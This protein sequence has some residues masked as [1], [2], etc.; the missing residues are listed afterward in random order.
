VGHPPHSDNSTVS[1]SYTGRATSVQDEG[2]G[3]QR[4]QRISQ[5]NGLGRLAYVCE[6]TN[7]NVLGTGGTAANCGSQVSTGL[8]IAGTGFLTTYTYDALNNLKSVSQGGYLPRTFAY[9]SLSRLLTAANPES[10]TITYGYDNASRLTTR[11][12][13]K[14]SQ[15]NSSVTVTTTMGYDEINRLRTKTYADSDNSTTYLAPSVTLNYDQTSALG[16]SGLNYT[17]GRESSAV[18]AGSQ[19]GE[20]FSYDKLGRA[21]VNSQCTPQNCSANTVFPITYNY[22]LLGD[23]TSGTNGMGVALNYTVNR[24]LRL[25]GTTSSLSDSNHPGTLYSS[26]R[27]NAAGSVVSTT[28]GNTGSSISETRSYDGR[29]RLTNITDG[30][31]YT[32]TIPTN[33]YAPNS[34]IL[35]ANDSVNGNW[36]YGYDAFNRLVSANATAQP[37]T[38]AY[39]RFGNRW[40]QNGPH[41][42]SL[43]FGGNNNRMD[44]YSYD[45]AGNLLYDG[46]TN[47]TYDSESRLISAT[48]G[49]STYQYDADGRRIRKTTTA[50]GT[51]DFLYDL[52]GHEMTQ[53][54]SAGVWNRGEVYAGGRHLAT[55]SGGA[56]GMT[57]FNFSNWLGT[58]HARSIPGATTPCETIASLPFGDGETT[59]GSCGDPSPM[60]FTG[61]ERDSESGLDDF[62]ARYYS[63][64]YGRFM[65]PDWAANATAVPYADFGNPQ[66]LNLYGYVK[67]NPLSYADP[68][69]HCC[70]WQDLRERVGASTSFFGQELVGVGKGVINLVPSLYNTVATVLNAESAGT[71]MQQDLPLAPTV[72]LNNLGQVVGS[73]VITL[74]IAATGLTGEAP[75]EAAVPDSNAVV[76]GGASEMPAQGTTF[77]GAH[78]AT[79]EG[80]AQGVPHGQIRTSTA[81]E[82]R[83]AGGSVRSAP[84]PTRSG[85]MNYKHVDVREG[86]KQPSTFSDPK[87]NPVPKKDRID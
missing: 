3:T 55:Y 4:V 45:A 86:K 38:Y 1:T 33:G 74:G 15:T 21:K 73:D 36:T 27:Y 63:S 40:Q 51:V 62:D 29:L 68:D 81:G 35:L 67:N 24:A 11:A 82:I 58:E 42:S 44:T 2:N 52:S 19:A 78:G 57:Y 9:D 30:S 75:S 66:S 14:P 46:T 60:H 87:P 8:D 54:T 56:G 39:D 83:G 84:E 65:T 85:K 7:S 71:D 31:L 64:Q 72:P 18:V 13:P 20:V 25:T 53:V 50:G 22:D 10:G 34:D 47:Y 16:V 26:P 76:R 23:M 61:K 5:V 70:D 69:G 59:T 48:N 77:S 41:S 37:Y 12:A 32:L 43:S 79:V 17:I 49:T 6:V 28:I 80:A